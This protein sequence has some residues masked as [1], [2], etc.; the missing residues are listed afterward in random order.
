M[1]AFW[2][3]GSTGCSSRRGIDVLSTV[4]VVCCDSQPK[5]RGSCG[6][7]ASR[8][9]CWQ[10]AQ[11]PT[12]RKAVRRRAEG[13]LP[14]IPRFPGARPSPI[15]Y[16]ITGALLVDA[17]HMAWHGKSA[18]NHRRPTNSTQSPQSPLFGRALHLGTGTALVA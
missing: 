14:A 8:G 6:A 10:L 1:G 7:G 15:A 4:S 11:G 9:C 13:W 18:A 3:I 17:W 5:C 12:P 2:K 16:H